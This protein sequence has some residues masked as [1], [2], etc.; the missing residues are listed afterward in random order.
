MPHLMGAEGKESR[1][2]S[3]RGAKEA[4]GNPHPKLGTLVPSWGFQSWPHVVCVSKKSG[5]PRHV[6]LPTRFKHDLENCRHFLLKDPAGAVPAIPEIHSP[7]CLP[8]L[9]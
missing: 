4:A 3:W 1:R 6:R 9:P 5:G 8:R 2:E 7:T